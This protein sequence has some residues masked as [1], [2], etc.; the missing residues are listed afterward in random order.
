MQGM[1]PRSVQTNG[2]GE[3]FM[4]KDAKSETHGRSFYHL[5]SAAS[6]SCQVSEKLPEAKLAN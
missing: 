2:A 1:D 4:S 3:S 5:E 6:A